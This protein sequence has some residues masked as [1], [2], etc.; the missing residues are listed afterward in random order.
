MLNKLFIL[1]VIALSF[2][3]FFYENDTKLQD[4]INKTDPITNINKSTA[5]QQTSSKPTTSNI[6]K[7]SPKKRSKTFDF[8]TL[9]RK[10][11]SYKKNIKKLYNK[12]YRSKVPYFKYKQKVQKYRQGG[13]RSNL[14]KIKNQ[15]ETLHK[16]RYMFVPYKIKGVAYKKNYEKQKK[17][18]NQRVQNMKSLRGKQTLNQIYKK[19]E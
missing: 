1:L 16:S 19:G 15:K 11:L 13:V 2:V 3:L 4:K 6:T 7:D 8:I 9:D 10:A 17:R 12:E 5:K 18:N 14:Q